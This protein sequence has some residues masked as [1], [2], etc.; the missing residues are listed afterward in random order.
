MRILESYT[1]KEVE[2]WEAYGLYCMPPY[3]GERRL[4]Q[5]D[6][7]PALLEFESLRPGHQNTMETT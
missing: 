3:S 2:D 4:C 7:K 1:S 6:S 5:A